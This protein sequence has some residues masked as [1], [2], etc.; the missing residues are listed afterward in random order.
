MNEKIRTDFEKVVELDIQ[1]YENINLD[2]EEGKRKGLRLT[3][4]DVKALNTIEKD[5]IEIERS[6]QQKKIEKERWDLDK[7]AKEDE[8]TRREKE[9]TEESARREREVA[10]REAEAKAAQVRVDNEANYQLAKLAID[11]KAARRNFFVT[12][13]TA[14]LTGGIAIGKAISYF[15]LSKRAQDYEYKEYKLEPNSSK[16]Q[17]NNLLK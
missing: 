17:R 7:K 8:M 3:I 2:D 9:Y 6:L 15:C 13:G 12:L 10:A 16:E 11:E 14:V 1:E 5:E 4:A